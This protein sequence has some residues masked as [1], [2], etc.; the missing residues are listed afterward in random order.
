LAPLQIEYVT[1]LK[2][3]PVDKA[4]VTASLH[5]H[6]LLYTP[7]YHPELQPIELIWATVKGRIASSL[8]KNGNDAVQKVLEGL[9]AIKG[10][11]FVGV[12][13]HAQ[14]FENDYAAYASE[15]GERK[16]MAAEDEL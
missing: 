11:E 16:L 2:E 3:K 14:T 13:R 10:T 1:P 4:Q 8:P 12:Y 6:Y 15:S 5:G 9:A 7:P